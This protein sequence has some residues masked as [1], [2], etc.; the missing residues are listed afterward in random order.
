VEPG[1]QDVREGNG[2]QVKFEA[3]SFEQIRST[4]SQVLNSSAAPDVLEY[5]KG[6]GHRGPDLQ[7]G[8]CLPTSTPQ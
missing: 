5:N 6:N 4:S 1:D 8:A 3:K 7:P 2:R